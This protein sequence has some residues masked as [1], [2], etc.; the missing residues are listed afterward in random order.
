MPFLKK[1]LLTSEKVTTSEEVYKGAKILIDIKEEV[2]TIRW[3]D[4][5][6]FRGSLNDQQVGLILIMSLKKKV[7]YT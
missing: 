4:L 6:N 7:F 3:K 5:D 2:V 1:T